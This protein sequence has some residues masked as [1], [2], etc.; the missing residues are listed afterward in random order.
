MKLFI[1]KLVNPADNEIGLCLTGTMS[2]M[3]M[4]HA[5]MSLYR[6]RESKEELVTKMED[7][8][9]DIKTKDEE[10]NKIVHSIWHIKENSDIITRYRTIAKF[11]SGLQPDIEQFTIT[12]LEN[13]IEKLSR[14]VESLMAV[15][16]QWE[17]DHENEAKTEN[18]T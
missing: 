9:N 7:L 2:F 15:F 14:A 18:K 1:N 4:Y 13:R 5:L 12:D 17:K 11:G 3:P 8:L 16:D 10:R 6:K